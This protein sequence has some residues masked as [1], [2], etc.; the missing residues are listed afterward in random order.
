[1]KAV[2]NDDSADRD[3]SRRNA[4]GDEDA[5][6]RNPVIGAMHLDRQVKLRKTEH[7]PVGGSDSAS[8]RKSPMLA[9]R[10]ASPWGRPEMF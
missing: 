6:G 4:S 1:M 3:N 10:P 9:W 8:G 2:E 7:G 5:H